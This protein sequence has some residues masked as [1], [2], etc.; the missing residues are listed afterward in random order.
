MHDYMNNTS[1]NYNN[2]SKEHSVRKKKHQE[3][4][5]SILS[6]LNDSKLKGKVEK[7]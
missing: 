3:T 2:V 6:N 1:I 7:I 4:M 5:N